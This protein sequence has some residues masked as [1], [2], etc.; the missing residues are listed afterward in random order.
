ML[1]VILINTKNLDICVDFDI[2]LNPKCSGGPGVPLS[3]FSCS[4]SQIIDDTFC[5]RL[6]TTIQK[7]SRVLH[8]VYILKIW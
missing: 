7:G 3:M 1:I 5:A 8:M 6:A 2:R 4:G